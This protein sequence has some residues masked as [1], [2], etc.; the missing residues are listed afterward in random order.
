MALN[1]DKYDIEVRNDNSIKRNRIFFDFMQQT[2]N[3][4]DELYLRER[5][6]LIDTMMKDQLMNQ[7]A[8]EFGKLN[9]EKKPRNKRK[10]GT[11]KVYFK[12]LFC[13]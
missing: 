6:L 8:A 1:K 4:L 10:A 5:Y 13:E 7:S 9:R 2:F 12:N 3:R 11:S